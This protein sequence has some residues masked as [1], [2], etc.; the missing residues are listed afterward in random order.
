MGR[1]APIFLL[2]VKPSIVY[3]FPIFTQYKPKIQ[4]NDFN[5]KLF[6]VIFPRLKQPETK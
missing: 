2:T 5:E 4:A 3:I 6:L 1:L